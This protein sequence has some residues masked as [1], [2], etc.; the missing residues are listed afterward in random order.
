MRK[1]TTASNLDETA[2]KD[3]EK[4]LLEGASTAYESLNKFVVTLQNDSGKETKFV[5]QRRGIAWKLT[6]IIL[7]IDQF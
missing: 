7:P 2:S 1:A 5:L 6:A 3:R 4:K